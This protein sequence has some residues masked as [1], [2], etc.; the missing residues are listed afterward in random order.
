MSVNKYLGPKGYS[1]RKDSLSI[2]EQIDVRDEL[3]VKAFVPPNSMQQSNPFPIYR[4]SNN[5]FYLPRFFGAK[6]FGEPTT[7]TIGD[8]E[9]IDLKFKGKLRPYQEPIVDTY[10]K[11]ADEIG[12]GLLEVAV[13]YGKCHARGTPIMMSNGEIKK[14][15]DIKVGDTLMGDDSKERRVLSLARGSEKMYEIKPT[16]GDSYTVNESHILSLRC[17]FT[18]GRYTKNQIVDICVRDYLKLPKYIKKNMLKGYRVPVEFKEK[19]VELDP[20]ILGCWLG[21]GTS[22]LPQLNLLRKYN[23]LNNKHIPQIY[24]CNSKDIRLNILAGIID[25][26]GSLVYNGCYDIIQKNETL[27]DDIIYVARSLGFAAYKTVCNKSCMYKGEK[28][29]GIYYRT[30]IH[31][32]G[33]EEIPIKL[34]R[35]KSRKREQ[36]KNVLNVGICVIEKDVDNYYGFE[37]D[38][39]RRFLLGDFTVTHNTIMALNIISKIKRKTLIVVHKEFLLRQWIERIDEFLPGAK[40]GKI[41]GEVVDV[42]NKDIVIGML[43]SLSMKDY[44]TKLFR[45]FGLTIFD[46]VHHMGAEVFSRALFKIVTK[47]M[48]GLSATMKRSD[49]L[50]KVFKM[51]IGPIVYTK[52]REGGD[53]VHVQAIDYINNDEEYSKVELNFKGHVHYSK[54]IKKICEFNHRS[55]FILK[56]LDKMLKDELCKQIMILGHNKVLLKYLHDAIEHRSMA[57]VGYY[58][59]GMKEKDLKISEGKK[60]VI[61]T[62]A[63]ASEGLDIKTLSSLI[64][65]TPKSSVEQC[66]GRILRTKHERPLVVDIVDQHEFFCKQWLKRKRFYVKEKYKI[67]RTNNTSYFNDEWVTIFDGV[68]KKKTYKKKIFKPEDILKGVCLIDDDD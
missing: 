9:E 49:N 65:A 22:R 54:M 24:K 44:S 34:E 8:G 61:A 27:L 57:T 5:K 39:N 68:K 28:K 29:T 23:V 20:Y 14:V 58:V 50:S 1:I 45:C 36:K 41:Q 6:R 55:E 13:G 48:L 16:K 40:V 38:G 63:M 53:G 62:Y 64:M 31:G 32:E 25:T 30:T 56:V 42:K 12:G 4:E 33:I 21:D 15:E 18:K 47:N 26:D 7:S 35:K 17:S 3:T 59:G 60:V 19:P 66:I 37:I 51:F 67:K 2:D 43:Q 10:V 52:R 46:E 11:K